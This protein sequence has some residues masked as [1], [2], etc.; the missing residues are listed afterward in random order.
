MA[1]PTVLVMGD[2]LSRDISSLEG[3]GPGGCRVLMVESAGKV[4]SRRWHAQRLHMVLSAMAHFAERLRAEGFDVDYRRAPSL[5]AGIDAHRRRYRPGEIVAM[6]P[7]SWG[8]RRALRAA[9]VALVRGNRFLSHYEDFAALTMEDFYR[10]QR[11]R[12]GV[13][14]NGEEP[15]GGRWNFDRENRRPPP[16][17][18]RSWPA[19]ELFELDEIDRAVLERMP[20]CWGDPPRGTWPVTREQALVR[21]DE[22]IRDGLPEFGA[23]QDAMLHDEWKLAHSVLGASLNIGLLGPAEVVARAEEAYRRGEAP[24]NSVEGFVRQVIGWR[25][26]VWGLYWLWMPEYRALNRLGAHEP[27]PACLAGGAATD[28]ACVA[29]VVGRLRERGYVHHIERLMVLGNLA[30]TAGVDPIAMTDWMTAGFVDSAEWVMLPNVLGMALYA[31]GGMMA[32]KP[33]AAGGAYVNRMSDFCS[34]CRYDPAR[35]TGE[36]AC[37]LT[38]LYWD[39]LARNERALRGNRRMAMPLAGLAKRDDLPEVRRRAAEVRRLLATGGV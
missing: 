20:H 19:V 13:L 25:E 33:Y 10:W 24:I 11:A 37:P 31:D 26:Y 14:L 15:A 36:A 7:S 21:L 8:A 2:Q 1:T 12:L 22:F 17:S 23:Y 5:A 38:T 28:M 4:A 30:L 34:S 27:V 29:S 35:R 16:R 6:E 39:F 32:T 9:G 18:A 3:L